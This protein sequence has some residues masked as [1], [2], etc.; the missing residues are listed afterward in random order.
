MA[1]LNLIK[2]VR[3][4][5]EG[6]QPLS[7]DD[8]IKVLTMFK[9][10]ILEIQHERK[11][12]RLFGLYIE[13][14][15][16]IKDTKPVLTSYSHPS[17]VNIRTAAAAFARY[18]TVLEYITAKVSNHEWK[19]QQE[20]VYE[21][22][23]RE[24]QQSYVDAL[25]RLNSS[26]TGQSNGYHGRPTAPGQRRN[27]ATQVHDILNADRPL[28]AEYCGKIARYM[29]ILWTYYV[30]AVVWNDDD[31]AESQSFLGTADA[32]R[33]YCPF[34]VSDNFKDFLTSSVLT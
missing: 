34:G 3:F 18:M 17:Q 1:A 27:V 4:T 14:Y 26:N 10:L 23:C 24:L 15:A 12:L 28:S 30:S 33:I 22:C 5:A 29:I 21:A 32:S 2:A 25:H 11:D 19:T 6:Y 16:R 9:D 13:E 7:S 31:C 20:V 8:L